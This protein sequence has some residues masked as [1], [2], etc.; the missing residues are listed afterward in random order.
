[1]PAVD[2]CQPQII[3]A[4]EKD[5]WHV[6]SRQ[7]RFM[8]EGRLIYIDLHAYRQ[9][10]GSQEEIFLAEVKCFADDAQYTHDLYTALGQVVMYRAILDARNVHTPL[11]L[12][13]PYHAYERV[14]DS[15]AQNVLKHNQVG[16][17]VV[18]LDEER[19]MVWKR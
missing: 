19:V 12:V 13:I 17:L 5:G 3:R 6:L 11:Y 10:N 4:L 15:I 9:V 2:V 7:S 18:D 8:V 16:L 1:M 14:F